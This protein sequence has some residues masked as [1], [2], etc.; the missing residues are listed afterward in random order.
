[1]AVSLSLRVEAY[2]CDDCSARQGTP[3]RELVR[4][5]PRSVVMNGRLVGDEWW[6]C[7]ICLTAKF[8]VRTRKDMRHG[9]RKRS[10]APRKREADPKAR[11]LALVHSVDHVDRDRSRDAAAL[12]AVPH[13][14]LEDADDAVIC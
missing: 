3:V 12:S 9:P 11:R 7:P 5:I 4:M 8:P 14:A 10:A 13:S 2:K 1:M 6:G